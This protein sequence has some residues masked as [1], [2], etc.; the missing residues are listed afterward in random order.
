MLPVLSNF[1]KTKV[2]KERSHKLLTKMRKYIKEFNVILIFHG[3]FYF[4]ILFLFFQ[5]HLLLGVCMY[6]LF[7]CNTLSWKPVFMYFYKAQNLKLK[8]LGFTMFDSIF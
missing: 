6:I 8:N 3:I 5:L 1:T 2:I 4:R 7:K